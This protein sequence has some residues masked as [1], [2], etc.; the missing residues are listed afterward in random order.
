MFF[1]RIFTK[2]QSKPV[3]FHKWVLINTWT[4]WIDRH[5][6]CDSYDMYDLGCRECHSLKTVDEVDYKKMKSHGL[7]K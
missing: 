2:K 3:C 5:Y 7:I 4:K 1:K 6:D